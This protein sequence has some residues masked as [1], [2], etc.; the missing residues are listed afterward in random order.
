MTM[1][2]IIHILLL[3][4]MASLFIACDYNE[5]NFPGMEEKEQI[6]NL[7]SYDHEVSTADITTIVNALRA[8]KTHE[9]SV[10][11]TALN[12]AKAFSP[13]IPSQS[14]IPYVLTATYRAADL[15]S[16]ANVTFPFIN[17]IPKYVTSLSGAGSYVVSRLPILKR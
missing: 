2:K 4:A 5:R 12:N 1:K 3:A 8:K 17:D 10:R 16:S 9:D 6:K 14:L 13:E 15:G 11:A 7:V